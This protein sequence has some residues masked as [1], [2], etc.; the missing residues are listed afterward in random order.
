MKTILYIFIGGGLGSVFRF[1]VSRYTAQ[2]FKLGTFPMGTLVVNVLGCFLIGLLSNSLMKQ[3]S[4]IVRYFFIVGLC[5]GFTTFSTFSYENFVLWQ[6]Q[7]YVT[8]FSYVVASLVL[9]FWAVYLGFKL[10]VV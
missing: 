10:G 5:G 2:F 7:D 4:D 6:N 9:G 3:E 1:L 8:L